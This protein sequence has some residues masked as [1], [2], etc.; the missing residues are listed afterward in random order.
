MP[1]RV[2]A[3][4][5][6][7]V[8]F[9]PTSFLS[10]VSV[11]K[12]RREYRQ[13]QIVFSQGDEANAVFY[14]SRGNV[15]MTVRSAR[16]KEAVI[17]VLE[18]GA[19]FGEGCLARQPR[20]RSTARAVRA[21]TIVRV[22]RKA[23]T[24]LLHGEPAFA[25]LFTSYLLSRNVRIEQD[26]IDQVFDSSEKRLARVLLVLARFGR[27]SRPGKV[28]PR[29]TQAALAALIGTSRAKVSFFMK[30]FRKL[31]FTSG[32]G[33]GMKVHRGLLDVLLYD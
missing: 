16:G 24:A 22:A 5:A 27:E 15:K 26:L 18:R 19:F 30:R 14:L 32:A 20:R 31:G 21:S 33:V 17:T 7:A 10:R 12:S 28:I 2:V 3:P 11:G 1:Q 13:G 29:I 8:A 23:M 4:L 6:R 9:N 25:A